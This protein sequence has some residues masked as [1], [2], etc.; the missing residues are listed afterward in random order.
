M[1][2]INMA[3]QLSKGYIIDTEVTKQYSENDIHELGR[4]LDARMKNLATGSFSRDEVILAYLSTV[5]SLAHY[6]GWKCT[7]LDAVTWPIL[8]LIIPNYQNDRRVDNPSSECIQ[9]AANWPSLSMEYYQI[10]SAIINS[11]KGRMRVADVKQKWTCFYPTINMDAETRNRWFELQWKMQSETA[12]LALAEDST[13]TRSCIE[14]I[15]QSVAKQLQL[16]RETYTP[17]KAVWYRNFCLQLA[18][19]ILRLQF[20]H[21]ND[22]EIWGEFS[23]DKLLLALQPLFLRAAMRFFGHCRLFKLRTQL[24]GERIP[25]ALSAVEV[26][27]LNDLIKEV[28]DSASISE[29]QARSFLSALVRRGK[30]E[31]YSIQAYPLIPLFGERIVFLPSAILYGNWPM[32]QQRL[33]AKK[34]SDIRDRRQTKRV[35]TV[36]EKRNFRH[37]ESDIVIKDHEEKPLTDLD[38]VI[39]SNDFKEVLVLQLKSFI[40]EDSLL[41][42]EKAD[43]HIA[44]A[45]R[46]CT[47]ATLNLNSVRHAIQS[48][49]NL[50]LH[51]DWKLRQLIIVEHSAGIGS[52]SGEYPVVSIAWLESEVGSKEIYQT[53]EE[54]WRAGLELPDAADFFNSIEPSFSLLCNQGLFLEQKFAIYGYSSPHSS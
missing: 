50:V 8:D 39:V 20:K 44:D 5:E 25:A 19:K 11:L 22:D 41:K 53:I 33:I 16:G 45:L 17:P 26:L 21:V 12:G 28:A 27:E 46:Q 32:I 31:N 14:S 4:I 24:L 7:A 35:R 6:Q 36:F 9:L 43:D 47:V 48:K 51:P 52:H 34:I 15:D 29:A 10:V 3:S 38:V 18:K 40:A 23:K 1:P 42:T 13:Y 2:I 37:L 54:I 30:E 49:M